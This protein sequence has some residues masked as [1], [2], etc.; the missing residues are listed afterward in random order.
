MRARM[1]VHHAGIA[2]DGLRHRVTVGARGRAL[3]RDCV[4]VMFRR[5]VAVRGLNLLVV[6]MRRAR[7]G[8]DDRANRL[9]R[10]DDGQQN[11]KQATHADQA[12]TARGVR[13][14]AT[15][16]SMTIEIVVFRSGGQPAAPSPGV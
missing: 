7:D 11:E 1:F 9:E 13:R 6:M 16:R 12:I 5:S 3:R 10:K 4:T 2:F 14:P 8:H 15:L